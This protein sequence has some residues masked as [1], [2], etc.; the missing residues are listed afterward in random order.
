[1]RN[2]SRN[3]AVTVYSNEIA[4]SL[5]QLIRKEDSPYKKGKFIYCYYHG[6]FIVYM[7]G[8]DSTVRRFIADV[9]KELYAIP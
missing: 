4:T 2:S 8:D 5:T 1:M 7:W 6:C 9:E 3:D